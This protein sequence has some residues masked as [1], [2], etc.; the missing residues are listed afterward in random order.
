[1]VMLRD[2][3]VELWTSSY[4]DNSFTTGEATDSARF[5]GTRLDTPPWA[6]IVT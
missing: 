6:L 5:G 1:M 4:L 3:A 2:M